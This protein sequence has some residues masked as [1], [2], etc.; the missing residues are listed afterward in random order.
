[1]LRVSPRI[2]KFLLIVALCISS[3]AITGCIESSFELARESRLPNGIKVPPGLTRTDVSVTLDY[4][5]ISTARFTLRDRKGK[6]LAEIKGKVINQY[7]LYLN[8]CPRRF[9]PACP[10]YEFI[11]VNGVT[12]MI[13]NRPYTEHENMEQNGRIVALFYV[14]DDPAVRGELLAGGAEQDHR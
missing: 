13:K 2:D 10:A 5:D 12:E 7:P 11:V 4:I 9:Y 8:S 3:C 1:M 14:I 6:K